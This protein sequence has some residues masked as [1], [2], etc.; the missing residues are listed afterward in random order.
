VDEIIIVVEV[1]ADSFE[2]TIEV[3]DAHMYHSVD[4]LIDPM[5]QVEVNFEI[6]SVA[7]RQDLRLDLDPDRGLN[8][9]RRGVNPEALVHRKAEAD[10]LVSRNEILI[11]IKTYVNRI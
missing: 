7:V 9:G 11:R 10:R 2:A 8:Q 5:D 1:G 3:A 4:E 6:G